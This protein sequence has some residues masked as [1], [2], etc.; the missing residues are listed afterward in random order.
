MRTYFCCAGL[1]VCM[2]LVASA[3]QADPMQTETPLQDKGL[4]SLQFEN[5]LFDGSD[6]WNTTSEQ[7]NY[8]FRPEAEWK[9]TILPY[10]MT[11]PARWIDWMDVPQAQKLVAITVGQQIF[12]PVSKTQVPPA[13]SDRPY[14]GWLYANLSWIAQT[15]VTRDTLQLSLGVVGPWALGKQAQDTMHD[16]FGVSKF[17]GWHYQLPNEP[18]VV[19]AYERTWRVLQKDLGGNLSYDVLPAAGVVVG[20]VYDYVSVGAQARFGWNLPDDFGHQ[21]VQPG[22]VDTPAFHLQESQW[23]VYGFVGAQGQAIARNMF[24]D[25]STWGSS[26]QINKNYGVANVQSGIAVRYERVSFIFSQVFRTKEFEDQPC[27]QWYC[28]ARL[29]VEF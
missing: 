9:D 13:S 20:N 5:D 3:A 4:L 2:S 6:R 14:A 8:T 7:V 19:I 22:S 29:L 21:I 23:S 17:E 11:A 25:G 1:F 27:P 10:W 24:L 15:E 18:A 28:S 26:A 16:I 12:T